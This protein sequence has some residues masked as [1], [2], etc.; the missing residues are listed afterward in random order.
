MALNYTL[1]H[2]HYI[3]VS[4]PINTGGC[5]TGGKAVQARNPQSL[6]ISNSIPL[7]INLNGVMLTELWPYFILYRYYLPK[8]DVKEKFSLCLSI[9]P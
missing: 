5:F 8:P 9:K 4:Y 6:W 7:Y 1:G 3:S 2:Y